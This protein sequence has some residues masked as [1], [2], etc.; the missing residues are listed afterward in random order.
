M[1]IAALG[2]NLLN[3]TS[4]KE[5]ETPCS[6]AS[7]RGVLGM[8]HKRV[9]TSPDGKKLGSFITQIQGRIKDVGIRAPRLG[10]LSGGRVGTPYFER[11][12]SVAAKVRLQARKSE[13]HPARLE[14]N[15]YQSSR[16]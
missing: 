8:R 11:P 16:L 4:W 10:S 6:G 9:F 3:A 5:S 1:V 14:K 13:R 2:S 15:F 12:M 7:G